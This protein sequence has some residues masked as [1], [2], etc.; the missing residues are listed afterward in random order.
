M[1]TAI[2][3]NIITSTPQIAKNIKFSL[4][5]ALSFSLVVNCGELMYDVLNGRITHDMANIP[6]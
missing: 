5:A 4:S 2:A 1:D 3:N 6:Q